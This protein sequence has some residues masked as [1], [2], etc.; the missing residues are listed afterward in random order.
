MKR[1]VKI[2]FISLILFSYSKITLANSTIKFIDMEKILNESVAGIYIKDELEKLHKSNLKKFEKTENDLKNEESELLSQRNI[3]SK[4][5]FEQRINKL[6]TKANLYREN[7]QKSLDDITEKRLNSINSLLNE[8]NPILANYSK[9]NSISIIIQK[10][11]IVMG[12]SELD[13]TNIILEA[14]NSKISKIDIN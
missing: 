1:L 6:R 12:K 8:V 10:K 9:E 11:N 7:R 3:L 5:Q 2:I 13:I 4:E 14:I